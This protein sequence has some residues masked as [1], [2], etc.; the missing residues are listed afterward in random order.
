ML[1][2]G[3]ELR[4]LFWTAAKSSTP[5]E[6]ETVM[7]DIRVLNAGAH[8]WLRRH[9]PKLW[10]RGFFSVFSKCES[11]DNNLCECF[12]GT[13]VDA[14]YKPIID[15]LE[16]IR[17][18]V[19]ER[20]ERRRKVVEKWQGEYCPR[21]LTRLEKNIDEHRCFCTTY[22][23]N[24]KFEVRMGLDGYVVDTQARSCS[25]RMWELSGIPCSHA[26]SAIYYLNDDPRKYIDSSLMVDK[27]KQAYGECMSSMNGRNLW[28]RDETDPIRPPPK[29]RMPGR[30]QKARR[31][32]LNEETRKV[33]STVKLIE[34]G[35]EMHCTNCKQLGHN[36]RSCKTAPVQG[37]Q[38]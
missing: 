28:P 29:R 11:V 24:Y 25:C 14:R 27:C 20:L 38:V 37:E 2:A 9:N 31:K 35:R 22:N 26:V 18:G 13:I 34:K 12:N 5:E 7:K 16:D 8:E 17:N 6:F 4:N 30:P 23:G 32:G 33:G 36:K 21:I 1:F 19:K 3:S 10:C 15:M